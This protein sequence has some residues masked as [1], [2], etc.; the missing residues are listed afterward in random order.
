MHE[1]CLIFHSDLATI[2]SIAPI[3]KL[4]TIS[5]MYISDFNQLFS[6]TND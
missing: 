3:S 5:F 6:Q 1:C 2:L 4:S